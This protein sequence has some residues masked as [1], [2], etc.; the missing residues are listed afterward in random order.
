MVPTKKED[1]DWT[2]QMSAA[3]LEPLFSSL[4]P[5]LPACSMYSKRVG[6]PKRM[7]WA[8]VCVVSVVRHL[9]L[10]SAATTIHERHVLRSLSIRE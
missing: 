5:Q 6:I 9:D 3:S 7:L 10:V 1:P 4:V 2:A 8:D